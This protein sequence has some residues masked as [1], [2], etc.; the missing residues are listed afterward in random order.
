MHPPLQPPVVSSPLRA[1]EAN[2]AR[3]EVL[4]P[5]KPQDR[6]RGLAVLLTR[7]VCNHARRGLGARRHLLYLELFRGE[8]CILQP[9]SRVTTPGQPREP[10]MGNFHPIACKFNG[11]CLEILRHRQAKGAGRPP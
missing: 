5:P 2:H 8:T 7:D 10:T 1:R 9:G 4:P 6:L 3:A 11:N